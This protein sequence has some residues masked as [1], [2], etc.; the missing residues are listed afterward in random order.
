M[1]FRYRKKQSKILPKRI[2]R[3]KKDKK[4]TSSIVGA[5]LGIS[6]VLSIM[7]MVITDYIPRW[8]EDKEAEH[9]NNVETDMSNLR[10]S[11]DQQILDSRLRGK[12][13]ESYSTIELGTR[14][15]TPF[16]VDSTGTFDIIPDSSHAWIGNSSMHFV[17][18][19]GK[20]VYQSYNIHY[21]DQDY[22]FENGA[23]ILK[24][25]SDDTMKFRISPQ[26]SISK[27]GGSVNVTFSMII[28]SGAPDTVVGS[29]HIKVKTQVL[30]YATESYIWAGGETI[31]Y[32]INTSYGSAWN[33]YFQS[34]FSDAG[35][36]GSFYTI[37]M[38]STGNEN[39]PWTEFKLEISNVNR[40]DIGAGELD[41]SIDYGW[42]T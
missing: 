2:S 28:I 27:V 32:W 16:T 19:F 10:A 39:H 9:M 37:T 8:L 5:L 29:Q 3:F 20:M 38:L 23:L 36:P 22:I 31:T 21:I 15:F 11:V 30:N 4:G 35:I 24:Q 7:T 34:A 14:S 26:F 40:L 17:E 1:T 42:K 13:Y 12:S 41:V 18:S 6:I 25:E 33:N